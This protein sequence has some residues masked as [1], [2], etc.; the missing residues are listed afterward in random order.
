MEVTDA[1]LESNAEAESHG[2]TRDDPMKVHPQTEVAE[3]ED[4]NVAASAHPMI[5]ELEPTHPSHGE[6]VAEAAVVSVAEVP[7]DPHDLQP[8]AQVENQNLNAGLAELPQVATATEGKEPEM[9]TQK[10]AETDIVETAKVVH[11]EESHVQPESSGAGRTD[12]ETE[13]AGKGQDESSSPKNDDILKDVQTLEALADQ[14]SRIAAKDTVAATQIQL[15]RTEDDG[16]NPTNGLLSV[17]SKASVHASHDA[18]EDALD[19]EIDQQ[20][21][22]NLA[23]APPENVDDRF[24]EKAAA[25]LDA[26]AVPSAVAKPKPQPKAAATP[27]AKAVAS[28]SGSGSTAKEK[29]AAAKIAKS[30]AKALAKSGSGM[31]R[32]SKDSKATSKD[33]GQ[34]VRVRLVLLG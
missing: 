20:G 29:S 3:V 30:A 18:L 5:T 21:G 14:T 2:E 31:G 24:E 10:G 9:T 34:R 26:D 23:M 25:A 28:T 32:R 4:A 13:I 27:K 12:L 11:A 6:Q 19:R 1:E 22:P 33:S 16:T 15:F 8:G 17:H 7:D